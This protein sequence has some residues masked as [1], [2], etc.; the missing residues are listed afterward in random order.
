MFQYWMGMVFLTLVFWGTTGITQKLAT[1]HMSARSS[2]I[3]FGLAFLPV[4]GFILFAADISWAYS[5]PLVGLAVLGGV[6]NALATFLV[7][8][9][10]ER[11]GK[12]SVVI[13]LVAL[14][15]LL[16]VVLAQV[17]LHERLNGRQ[18]WGVLLA[19]VAG[20]L[21]SRESSEVAS[22]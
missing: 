7:F 19:I 2:A 10:L 14:Y 11:G 13:P 3:W 20:L 6:L 15:P 22:E 17:F 9:A 12:A 4:S 1:N 16:T 5:L 8:N 18:W 21:L